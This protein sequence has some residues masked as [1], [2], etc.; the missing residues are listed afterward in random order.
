MINL[1]HRLT[2]KFL[3]TFGHVGSDEK[4]MTEAAEVSAQF[5][6]MGR[7]GSLVGELY[8][9]NV[10][11]TLNRAGYERFPLHEIDGA[12]SVQVDGKM[13]T[14]L[15]VD[16]LPKPLQGEVDSLVSGDPDCWDNL[17]KLCP[18]HQIRREFS[19][20][21]ILI[22]EAKASF[23]TAV[24]RMSK[25]DK[26]DSYYSLLNKATASRLSHKVL[27][28]N[29]GE[30]SKNWVLNGRMASGIDGEIW[31]KLEEAGI[32]LFYRESFCQDWVVSMTKEITEMKRDL[33][34]LKSRLREKSPTTTGNE[35]GVAEKDNNKNP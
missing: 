13:D 7:V 35:V 24:R 12:P 28:I 3:S 6:K 5:F 11:G 29:G 25:T 8:E 34:D 16:Y 18:Y 30:D 14:G 22:V 23:K 1:P 19:D 2:L 15:L 20:E 27:F 21:H 33:A 26:E 17:K 32:S 10:S 31:T 4:L 9:Y